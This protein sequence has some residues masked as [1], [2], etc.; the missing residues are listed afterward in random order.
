MPEEP[1]GTATTLQSKHIGTIADTLLAK[2]EQFAKVFGPE[3]RTAP[4]LRQAAAALL[5]LLRERDELARCID[6]GSRPSDAANTARVRDPVKPVCRDCGSEDIGRDA[7]ARWDEDLQDWSLTAVY[8]SVTCDSCGAESDN[9]CNWQPLEPTPAPLPPVIGARARI[10]ERPRIGGDR[11]KG[12]E[13]EIVRQSAFGF[14][15]R[16]DMTPRERVQK[17]ELVEAPFLDVL[18]HPD[19]PE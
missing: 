19:G 4:D 8:D 2:A 12:R 9:L 15:L 17:V 7:T 3:S 1:S 5:S 10:L 18:S 14:Y 6:A 13:G 11:F 16:L